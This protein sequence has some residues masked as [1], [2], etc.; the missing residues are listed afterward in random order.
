M[1]VEVAP[2]PPLVLFEKETPE[3]AF[4]TFADVLTWRRKAHALAQLVLA[5][6]LLALTFKRNALFVM[7]MVWLARVLMVR[8]VWRAPR[9]VRS[10]VERV[11]DAFSFRVWAEAAHQVGVGLSS[12]ESGLRATLSVGEWIQV[13]AVLAVVGLIPRMSVATVVCLVGVVALLVTPLYVRWPARLASKRAWVRK[14]AWV[15]E[16]LRPP[17]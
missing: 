3:Q 5:A 12:P 4:R 17:A 16:S 8:L 1:V 10:R 9:L 13:S 15:E 7:G 14:W 2:P 6:A 11:A